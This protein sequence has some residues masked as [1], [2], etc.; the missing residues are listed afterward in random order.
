MRRVFLLRTE[1]FFRAF[2][3]TAETFRKVRFLNSLGLPDLF[4]STPMD[5]LSCRAPITI[6]SLRQTQHR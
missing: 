2:R 5:W 1:R 3:F 6:I 4:I